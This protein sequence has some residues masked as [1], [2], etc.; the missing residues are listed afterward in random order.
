MSRDKGSPQQPYLAVREIAAQLQKDQRESS[1]THADHLVDKIEALKNK[2][3]SLSAKPFEEMKATVF[4]WRD[5]IELAVSDCNAGLIA[6]GEMALCPAW[7]NSTVEPKLKVL[8]EEFKHVENA[9]TSIQLEPFRELGGRMARA[10][11]TITPTVKNLSRL[12]DRVGDMAESVFFCREFTTDTLSTACQSQDSQESVDRLRHRLARLQPHLDCP[13]AR[14]T[15]QA[16]MNRSLQDLE[17]CL[18]QLQ[19]LVDTI[20]SSFR[21]LS[22]FFSKAPERIKD[23]LNVPPPCSCMNLY[24]MDQPHW[25]F[26]Q[27]IKHT[28]KAQD[29]LGN[30]AQ[31]NALLDGLKQ[32]LINLDVTRIGAPVTQFSLLARERLARLDKVVDEV[33]LAS[34][35]GRGRN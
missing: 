2:A 18:T 9:S 10:L 30:F 22:D 23:V 33:N 28:T 25:V 1:L 35:L 15:R 24:V 6:T 16:A 27:L 20:Q 29:C 14:M 12:P 3:S 21:I 17:R 32:T 11:S 34:P 5:A 4:S 13:G 26:F 8:F 19:E 7:Y 31:F